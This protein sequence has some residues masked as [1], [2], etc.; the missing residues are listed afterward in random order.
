VHAAALVE[1]KQG[2]VE[3]AAVLLGA[4]TRW[5]GPQRGLPDELLPEL[6][7]LAEDVRE[8]LGPEAFAELHEQGAILDLGQAAR[9]LA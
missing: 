4:A 9:L 7:S 3:Q 1:L 8:R 6:A 2:R 5:I